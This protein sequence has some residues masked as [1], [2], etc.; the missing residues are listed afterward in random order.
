MADRTYFE[1]GY[2]ERNFQIVKFRDK[3]DAPCKLQISSSATESQLWIGHCEMP[4][5]IDK[6]MAKKI[7][8][9]LQTWIEKNELFEVSEA[10]AILERISRIR[11]KAYKTIKEM[12]FNLIIEIMKMLDIKYSN[13]IPT[14][15]KIKAI[16]KNNVEEAIKSYVSF[17]FNNKVIIRSGGFA[18]KIYYDQEFD[19]DCIEIEFTPVREIKLA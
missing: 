13:K 7:I 5:L 6:D 15:D 18:V 8:E 10:E 16:L 1:N 4:I 12:E 17:G 11:S 3:Y 14:E 2:T 9:Y 19:T